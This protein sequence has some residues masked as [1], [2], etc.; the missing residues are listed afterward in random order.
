MHKIIDLVSYLYSR[1]QG[2]VKEQIQRTLW[3]RIC[4]KL[5][6][7]TFLAVMIGLLAVL[8]PYI[9]NSRWLGLAFFP[10]FAG[11][12]VI[13]WILTVCPDHERFDPDL[14]QTRVCAVLVIWCLSCFY[15]YT[16]S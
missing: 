9:V 7:W 15:F 10:I 11:T 14:V 3:L 13:G 16:G 2:K 12:V 8:P 6:R 4:V 5:L 1:Q